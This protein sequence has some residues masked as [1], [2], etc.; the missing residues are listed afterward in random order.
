MC[1][2]CD[3]FEKCTCAK[4]NDGVCAAFEEKKEEVYE[5]A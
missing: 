3:K 1:S 4:E 5:D 2:M